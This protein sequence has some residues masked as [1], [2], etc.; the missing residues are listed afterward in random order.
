MRSDF[1]DE[2]GNWECIK[3]GACCLNITPVYPDLDRGDRTCKFLSKENTCEIYSSRPNL[4][5]VPAVLAKSMPIVM[6]DTCNTLR[7][8][9]E[10]RA[11]T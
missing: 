5:R 2:S 4:C 8:E 10:K 9:M 7:T 11:S 1:L 3:C 6:A